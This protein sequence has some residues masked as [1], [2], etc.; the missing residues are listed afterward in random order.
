[1]KKN[2]LDYI[3][4]IMFI[5]F[6]III[7]LSIFTNSYATTLSNGAE[8][9]FDM[10]AFSYGDTDSNDMTFQFTIYNHSTFSVK[11]SDF[12]IYLYIYDSS[13]SASAYAYDSYNT[14]GQVNDSSNNWLYNTN[15]NW[16]VSFYDVV[17]GSCGTYD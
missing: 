10:L 8:A 7:I 11:I 16:N 5:I 2:I 3:P 6:I 12:R 13:N 9:K 4:T 14:Q 15:A 17:S 1:M